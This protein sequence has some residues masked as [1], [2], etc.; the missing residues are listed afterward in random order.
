MGVEAG[1]NRPRLPEGANRLKKD[2][3]KL[4]WGWLICTV[5]WNVNTKKVQAG[6]TA[7]WRD[8]TDKDYLFYSKIIQV[9]KD[10]RVT[11]EAGELPNGLQIKV[12]GKGF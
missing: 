2:F 6:N 5:G 9:T 4:G 12:R 8:P 7:A 3:D 11:T 1:L 10:K